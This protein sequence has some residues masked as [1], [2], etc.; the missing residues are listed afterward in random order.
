MLNYTELKLSE[1]QQL[2][3]LVNS[4][5][6]FQKSK[7]TIKTELFDTMSFETRLL[8]SVASSTH[9]F[10]VLAK[11]DDKPIGYVY[12]N[13]APK[14]NYA[15]DFATFFDLKSINAKNVGC[16]SQFYIDAN[17][18]NKGIGSKLFDVAKKWMDTFTDVEDQFIFVSNG[19]TDALN[20][21]KNKGFKVSH[22]IL[23]GFITVLRN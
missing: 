21:Y 9:N 5:M 12:A 20:F 10:F 13:I 17:Y 2:K 6:A 8:P 23:E 1:I 11:D 4:L 19:N 14:E 7:A 16:L 18:R 15:N 3:P 22:D